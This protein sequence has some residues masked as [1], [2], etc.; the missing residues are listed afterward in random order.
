MT[1]M[2]ADRPPA[3]FP[4]N[5]RR[6]AAATVAVSALSL[7][8]A[9]AARPAPGAP[10]S[11][12]RELAQAFFGSTLIR[13]EVVSVVGRT[14]H[15]FRIDQGRL[16]A[17]RAGSLDL[18]E[19]DGTQQTIPIGPATQGTALVARL[20][21]GLRLVTVRDG[22][23]PA[24]QIYLA[25]AARALG[26]TMLGGTLA[27]AEMV[28]YV[29]KTVH[30]FRIDEGRVSSVRSGSV[31]LTERDGTEQSIDVTPATQVSIFGLAADMS[32]V[33]KGANVISIREGDAPA[34]EIRILTLGSV[35]IGPRR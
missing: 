20:P 8:L 25:G 15:D 2:R 19:K 24:T 31:T 27:R 12:A 26:R 18:L 28:T 10:P 11:A 13:A 21:R 5:R 22:D 16:T 29:G 17:F 35:R 1:A 3:R 32:A 23:G 9:T 30:D 4:R 7:F 33:T 34:Q 14:V 6:V